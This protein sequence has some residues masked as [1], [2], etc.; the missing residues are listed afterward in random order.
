MSTTKIAAALLISLGTFSAS[1]QAIL[2][3][4]YQTSQE[5]RQLLEGD[6][7][8]K[9]LPSGE[10]ILE[11]RRNEKGYEITTAHY[12]VQANIN[13]IPTGHPGPAQFEVEFQKA[14]KISVAPQ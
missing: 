12:H 14:D 9:A 4:L 10:P 5:L 7:L 13:Y 1:L 8:G 2:P 6:R 3:P 11:I